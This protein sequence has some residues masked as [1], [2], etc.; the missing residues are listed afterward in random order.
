MKYNPR[1]IHHLKNNEEPELISI[2]FLLNI[3][4]EVTD[5]V[6]ILQEI[7][8]ILHCIVDLCVSIGQLHTY[9]NQAITQQMK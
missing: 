4:R 1:R 9:I 3:R 7:L 6:K 2:T 8:I 5:W